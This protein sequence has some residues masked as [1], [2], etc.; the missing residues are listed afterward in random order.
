MGNDVKL[1]VAFWIDNLKAFKSVGVSIEL[2]ATSSRLKA[3]DEGACNKFRFIVVSVTR[4]WHIAAW[5][6]AK[7]N[8]GNNDRWEVRT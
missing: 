8:K 7:S 2:G 4:S 1:F 3:G 6:T 5:V